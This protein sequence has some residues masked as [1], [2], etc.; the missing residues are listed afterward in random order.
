MVST[1]FPFL[2][3]TVSPPRTLGIDESTTDLLAADRPDLPIPSNLSLTIASLACF[4]LPPSPVRASVLDKVFQ[5]P[6]LPRALQ[7]SKKPTK[8]PNQRSPAT[9]PSELLI[10][11]T[12]PSLS[13][14][15]SN[16]F[17]SLL[18]ALT[19]GTHT[20]YHRRETSAIAFPWSVT[21]S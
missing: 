2:H 17:P 16:S 10:S 7:P 11:P 21:L 13:K 9:P 1:F 6:G 14:C 12:S 4:L 3:G 8:A 18:Q 5:N 19:A 20:L 15:F